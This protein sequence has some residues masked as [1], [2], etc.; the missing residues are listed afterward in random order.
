MLH[1]T[2]SPLKNL[3]LARIEQKCPKCKETNDSSYNTNDST[4]ARREC[5]KNNS[6]RRRYIFLKQFQKCFQK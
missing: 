1:T 6:S 4:G 3:T 5:S 2:S